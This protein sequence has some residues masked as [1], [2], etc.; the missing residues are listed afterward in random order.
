M[1][2]AIIFKLLLISLAIGCIW[3][4]NRNI[5]KQPNQLNNKKIIFSFFGAPGSGKGTLAEQCVKNLEYQTLSTGNLCRKHIA[6]DTK[7]GKTIKTFTSQGKLV[8]DEV[9]IEMV[10]T[11][12]KEKSN[13]NK[14]IILDGFPRT[15]TQA[16]MLNKILKNEMPK[17]DFRIIRLVIPKEEIVERLVNRIVCENKKCQAVY[18][19]SMPEA[20][21]GI[22]PKCGSK[23]IKREDDTK[24]VIEKRFEVYQ[25]N[26]N[27][28]LNFYR[29]IG[30]KIEEI[31]ISK[32]S[33]KEVFE[34]FKNII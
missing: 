3:M 33:P 11:W 29:S 30:Q 2:R 14:P 24:E 7:I 9:I 10:T 15:K 23:L 1:A 6:K 31:N 16:E 8:P 21:S 5:T 4:I 26:E 19:T 20:K 27:K 18:N 22:C 34:N 25:E 17:Y 12:L 13:T 28:I 32:L